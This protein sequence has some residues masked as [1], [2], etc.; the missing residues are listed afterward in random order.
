MRKEH[1]P[2]CSSSALQGSSGLLVGLKYTLSFQTLK[3]VFKSERLVYVCFLIIY[4]MN[5]MRVN[6]VTMTLE[7]QLRALMLQNKNT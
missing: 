6:L 5:L 7:F 4:Y 3:Q 1:G 2:H